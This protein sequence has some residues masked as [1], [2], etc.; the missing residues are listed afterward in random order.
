MNTRTTPANPSLAVVDGKTAPLSEILE[1]RDRD[2]GVIVHNM[3]TPH[4]V[5]LMLEELKSKTS[6]TQVGPQ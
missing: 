5:T 3:L 6:T 1:I 2:G 4:V